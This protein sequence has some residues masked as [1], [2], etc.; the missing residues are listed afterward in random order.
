[1]SLVDEGEDDEETE[2][3]LDYLFGCVRSPQARVMNC[4][5]ESSWAEETTRVF[6]DVGKVFGESILRG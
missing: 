5:H 1:M 4:T 2:K 3:R 6:V